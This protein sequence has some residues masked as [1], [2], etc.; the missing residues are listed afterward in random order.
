MSGESAVLGRFKQ[1]DYTGPNRCLPCTVLNVVI[2][3]AVSLVASLIAIPLGVAV[4]TVSIVA[5]Y[6]RGYLVPGTPEL[7]KQYMPEWLRT[8]LHDEGQTAGQQWDSVEKRN[9]TRRDAVDPESFLLDAGA[10]REG[11]QDL[12][13]AESFRETVDQ[14]LGPI[15]ESGVGDQTL[16]TLFDVDPST[17]ER[18]DGD[19]PTVEIGSRR[20]FW[21]SEAA[22][23]CDA[24]THE[25]LRATTEDWASVPFEQRLDVLSALRSFRDTCPL[26]SGSVVPSE[27]VKESCCGRE[28]VVAFTCADCDARIL[29]VPVDVAT[30]P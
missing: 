14:Q 15:R 9:Q 7:T 27:E 24:A 26:C 1:P 16:A 10:I 13:L 5:I 17:I 6:F 20:R 25:A 22:F 4:L 28:E 19:T 30:A 29:E 18:P 8:R 3:I 2:A 12:E 21:P 11:E 23:F